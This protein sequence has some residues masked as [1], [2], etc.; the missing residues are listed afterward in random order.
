[1][2]ELTCKIAKR[3]G[4]SMPSQSHAQQARELSYVNI[5]IPPFQQRLTLK[6]VLSPSLDY[7]KPLSSRPW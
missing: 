1:M 4:L 6:P 5:T 7:R 3:L 2:E